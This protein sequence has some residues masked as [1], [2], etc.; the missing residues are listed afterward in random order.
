M[1]LILNNE[2][3]EDALNYFRS[4]SFEIE[5][6]EENKEYKTFDYHSSFEYTEQELV[7]Q[8]LRETKRRYN[9]KTYW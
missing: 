8:Y 6:I 2:I 9:N 3:I 1:D 5:Y 4:Q 7:L